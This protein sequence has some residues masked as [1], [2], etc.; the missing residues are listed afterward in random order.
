M[1]GDTTVFYLL[2][3]DKGLD[4]EERLTL[5]LPDFVHVTYDKEIPQKDPITPFP[6][7]YRVFKNL[8]VFQAESC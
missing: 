2:I 1:G 5:T 4:R 8:S 3:T 6:A 7:Y